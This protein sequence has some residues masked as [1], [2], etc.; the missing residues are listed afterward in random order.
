MRRLLFICSEALST[1][2]LGERQQGVA[3]AGLSFVPGV[4][5]ALAR[6]A[7]ETDFGFVRILNRPSSEEYQSLL[8]DILEGEGVRFERESLEQEALNR[9][10]Y[11]NDNFDLSSSFVVGNPVFAKNTATLLGVRAIV[12]GENSSLHDSVIAQS[13]SEIA[14]F[15]RSV[16]HCA[17]VKRATKETAVDVQLSL[18]GTAK[19]H[20]ATGLGF[21]DHMLDLLAHHAGFDLRI[22]A[23]GDL[24]VDEH[25]LVEDV[26]I[27]LGGAI[28]Q[29]MKNRSGMNR[30]GFLLPMDES[31]AQIA[32]DLSGRSHLSWDVEF[33]RERVGDV[34]TEMFKH[35]FQSFADA[36]RMTMH[37]SVTGE[38]EH[39]KIESVFKGVGRTLR[40]AMARDSN[41]KTVPSTKG[42]L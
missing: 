30:Y 15:L 35:F 42:V 37:I 16:E 39:H 1:T 19:V 31:L 11:S 13:W 23:T 28:L 18:Y 34:P 24:H 27:T 8:V 17:V 3:S 7:E 12:L 32:I 38:N 41:Q 14:T 22:S 33:K 21:L 29:A 20:I 9:E 2:S 26:G 6:V 10:V 36:A 4:I 25:H 5:S 40:S